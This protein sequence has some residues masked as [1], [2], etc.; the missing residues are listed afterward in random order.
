MYFDVANVE[1]RQFVIYGQ[2]RCSDSCS[3]LYYWQR[4]PGVSQLYTELTSNIVTSM[5]TSI[6]PSVVRSSC[7]DRTQRLTNST[8]RETWYVMRCDAM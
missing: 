4:G 8:Y 1:P 5:R 2:S 3:P 6:R 7:C